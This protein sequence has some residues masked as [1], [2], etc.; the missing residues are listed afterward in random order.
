MERERR[1]A[2]VPIEDET[3]RQIRQA[4]EQVGVRA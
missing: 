1:A 4:A 3:W 2:G